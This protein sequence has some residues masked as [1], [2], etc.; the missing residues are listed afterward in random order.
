MKPG[1]NDTHKI[2]ATPGR[3]YTANPS[4]TATVHCGTYDSCMK[5]LDHIKR[6]KVRRWSY[7]IVEI[8]RE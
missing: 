8:E 5:R 7:R 3:E 1:P 6:Q 4:R 2:I